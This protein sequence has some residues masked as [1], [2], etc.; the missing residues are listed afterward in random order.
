MGL[1]KTASSVWNALS[2]STPYS[3]VSGMSPRGAHPTQIGE[4]ERPVSPRGLLEAGSQILPSATPYLP[5]SPSLPA[6]R[7]AARGLLRVSQRPG[8][9]L[10]THERLPDTLP[11]G[12]LDR[13]VV[14]VLWRDQG[15]APRPLQKF[16]P[17]PGQ[18]PGP[19]LRAGVL[20]RVAAARQPPRLVVHARRGRAAFFE[21]LPTSHGVELEEVA[22]EA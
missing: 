1:S 12:V 18:R 15:R 13:R 16:P 17:P 3:N 4:T 2:A 20:Q 11:D 19:G 6:P 5:V 9:V 10:V 8:H 14:R 21:H 22:E 7:G